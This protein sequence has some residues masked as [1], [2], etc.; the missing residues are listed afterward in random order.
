MPTFLEV[1]AAIA[2]FGPAV[3]LAAALIYIVIYGELEFRYPRN[4]PPRKP[5]NE[6]RQARRS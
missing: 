4:K 5:R 2:K 1:V 6:V 3:V